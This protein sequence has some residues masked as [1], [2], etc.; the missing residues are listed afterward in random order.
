MPTL[1]FAAAQITAAK[2][3]SSEPFW[4]TEGLPEE[5]SPPSAWDVVLFAGKPT[6]GIAVVSGRNG[7]SLDKKKSPGTDGA[8]ITALGYEPAEVD[9]AIRIWTAAQWAA[10]QQLRPVLTARPNKGKP[11]PLQVYHPALA[12]AGIRSLYVREIG[13][14]RDIQPKGTK[15]ILIRCSEWLPKPTGKGKDATFTPKKSTDFTAVPNALDG[16]TG[17]SSLSL[18]SS[19]GANAGPVVPPSQKKAGP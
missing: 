10:W 11:Q 14:P 2:P 17:R 6:P 8:T 12:D 7:V 16:G 5:L 18:G 19:F 1:S 15:E 4:D 9:I 13:L 3:S